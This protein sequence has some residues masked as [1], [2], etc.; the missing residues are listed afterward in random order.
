MR[1]TGKKVK[2]SQ[3][4]VTLHSTRRHKNRI[5]RG[6]TPFDRPAKSSN[7]SRDADDKNSNE[8][9]GSRDSRDKYDKGSHD[10]RDSRTNDRDARRNDP[11]TT[12]VDIHRP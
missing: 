11:R 8:R 4:D 9:R 10:S 7:K 2:R 1:R 5:Q 6:E 3:S 12:L